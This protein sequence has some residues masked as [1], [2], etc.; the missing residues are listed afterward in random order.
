MSSLLGIL[1]KI[2]TIPLTAL[3]KLLDVI[4]A[5]ISAVLKPVWKLIVAVFKPVF[6]A[7]KK[8]VL[9]LAAVA[10]TI[11]G[12]FL[13]PIFSLLDKT[14]LGKI[15]RAAGSYFKGSYD[16]LDNV[17]WPTNKETWSMS[18]VVALFTI[19]LT[20]FI[21]IADGII[22]LLLRRLIS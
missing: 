2:I 7:G 4:W 15:A 1:I 11:L 5:V 10:W 8:I 17:K 16:E 18:G 14:P 22:G 9:F 6:A 13:K 19:A 21:V 12:P 20:L 3:G